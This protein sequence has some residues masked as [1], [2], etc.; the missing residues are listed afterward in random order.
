M[1]STRP[2]SE[3]VT[4]DPPIT[5]YRP[6]TWHECKTAFKAETPVTVKTVVCT[7]ETENQIYV[8]S[9]TGKDYNRPKAEVP[10]FHTEVQAIQSS[11]AELEAKKRYAMPADAAFIQKVI[12]HI[13][14]SGGF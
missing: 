9:L 6:P 8:K 3:R 11:I 13:R 4:H 7:G 1:P 14:S 12:S 10:T 5:L 2:Y